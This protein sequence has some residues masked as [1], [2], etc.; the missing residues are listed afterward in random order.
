MVLIE[1]V[2]EACLQEVSLLSPGLLK[3]NASQR[4]TGS[5]CGLVSNAGCG[6]W[7]APPESDALDLK[8]NKCFSDVFASKVF[9]SLS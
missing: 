1:T 6:L 9:E 8:W 4:G 7:A 2:L 5:F 3:S